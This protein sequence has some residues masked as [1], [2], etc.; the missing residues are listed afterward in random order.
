MSSDPISNFSLTIHNTLNGAITFNGASNSCDPWPSRSGNPPLI[1]HYIPAMSLATNAVA[2]C[3]GN[4]YEQ[5]KMVYPATEGKVTFNLP[6]ASILTF[7][8]N[9][10]EQKGDYA[11]TPSVPSTSAY[12][13]IMSNSGGNFT[14]I[15]QMQYR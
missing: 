10:Y 6:D 3:G 7:N 4:Y 11:C 13:V 2:A 12:E 15:I 8:W 5:P 14:A 1:T 9:V